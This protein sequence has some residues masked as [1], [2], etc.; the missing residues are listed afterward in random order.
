MNKEDE[1]LAEGHPIIPES[2]EVVNILY[3]ELD[4]T[5]LRKMGFNPKQ[6]T[7]WGISLFKGEVPKSF[8]T[9]EEF[10]EHVLSV[11][12]GKKNK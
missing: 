9:L 11:S 6:V 3:G 12:L 4:D 8:S 10:E 5:E 7:N 2:P 1:P